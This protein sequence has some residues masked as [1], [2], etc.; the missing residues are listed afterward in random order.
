MT[1]EALH[2]ERQATHRA[3]WWGGISLGVLAGAVAAYFV[4]KS[5]GKEVDVAPLDRAESLIASCES[6]IHDIERAI[7]KLGDATR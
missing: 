7:E 4:V 6:R 5:R 1:L 2:M 3:L